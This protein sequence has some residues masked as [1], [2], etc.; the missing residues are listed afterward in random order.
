[1]AKKSFSVVQ[2]H[3]HKWTFFAC[4]LVV[5][6]AMLLA[7]TGLS[8]RDPT[9]RSREVKL[10]SV[11][12][13][14]FG[15]DIRGG[16]EAVYMPDPSTFSEKP[17]DSQLDAVKNIMETR[18][19]NLQILD[20]DVIIDRGNGRVSVRFPWRSDESSFKPDEAIR[21]L[22]ETAV[23]S[24]VGPDNKTILTGNDV[25]SARALVNNQR[26]D[27]VVELKLK[28]E[29]AKKFADATAEFL[30]K[31]IAIKM[32]DKTISSPVVQAHITDGVASITSIKT[33]EEA[34][35]LADKINAGALPFA[36]QAVSSR[37]LSPDLGRSALEVMVTAGLVG[38][39]LLCA[40]LMLRYRLSGFVAT[41][42][43]AAQ[44][45]G[46]LLAIS[47]P[48]QTLT[49][50]GIAGV[51]ISIG[52]GTDANI[53]EAER[54]REELRG[55]ATVRQAVALGFDKAFSSILDGNVTVAI[56]AVCLIY[57]GSG[58]MLSFG[59]SLLVGVILNLL[60]GAT[61]SKLMTRSLI[62]F[63]ALRKA[64]CFVSLKN[65]KEAVESL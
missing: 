20:R 18:L 22:G 51:I 17:S 21:E 24:F 6:L 11:S 14:R 16:V 26:N 34:V 62:E 64:A 23:L 30:H 27:Y 28:S 48:Q 45:V 12:N 3:G 1:M 37:S 25:E 8:F 59:Y 42:S 9:N 61:L 19:D 5:L 10:H 35:D 15:I 7:K 63:K 55:G 52:M 4:L 31:Q 2:K 43:L 57:L 32:D 54:I 50:Q 65:R 39:L 47:I 46:I 40:F 29:G 41:I 56:A 38:F 44:L 53:I 60:C 58:A 36:I 49:L 13:I 33:V